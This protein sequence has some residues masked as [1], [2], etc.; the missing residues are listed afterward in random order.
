MVVSTLNGCA[1]VRPN[2]E[3]ARLPG[4]LR[5]TDGPIVSLKLMASAIAVSSDSGSVI[6]AEKP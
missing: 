3:E 4:R 6:F 1:Y 2:I 5:V